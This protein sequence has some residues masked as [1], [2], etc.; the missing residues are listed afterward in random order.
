[1]N[2]VF[3]GANGQRIAKYLMA[4]LLLLTAFLTVEVLQGLKKFGYIGKEIYPQRTIMASGEGEAFAVPDIAS[5]S[6]SVVENAKTVSE[7]QKTADAKIA[8]AL[9]SLKDKG[10]EDK[11]IK[12]TN[13]SFYPKYEWQ[14]ASCLETVYPNC[15]PGKNILT[16]YEVNQTITVKVR[17]TD[18]AGDLVTEMGAIGASNISG[19]EFTVDDREKYVSQARE[20]A[21]K[22]AKENAKKLAK[23]LGVSL[24]KML[25][26]NENGNYP[27]PYYA[28]GKGG[29]MDMAVSSVPTRAELPVGESKIT[30]NVSITYE[31]K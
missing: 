19:V 31:I 18:K 13:Y 17:E 20:E 28:E 15:P 29:G 14:A 22:K 7:A 4:A 1:M 6:F 8:R 24:G 16:G 26:F 9:K 11:D 27:T 12:T 10:I 30:S 3:G 25:Y 2:E 5:F 21:I 23:D